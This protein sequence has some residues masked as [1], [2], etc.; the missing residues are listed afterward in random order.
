VVQ[1]LSVFFATI[2]N[3]NF[4]LSSL[5]IK[6]IKVH[7]RKPRESKLVMEYNVSRPYVSYIV[8]VSVIDVGPMT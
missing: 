6:K 7:H 1:G 2:V 5:F 8:L 3:I 4:L